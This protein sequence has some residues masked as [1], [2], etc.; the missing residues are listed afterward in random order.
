[1][2]NGHFAIL[3]TALFCVRYLV[4]NLD[5]AG[6]RLDHFLGEKISCFFITKA[7]INI[8][9]NRHNMR[10]KIVNFSQSRVD[11]TAGF[12]RLIQ[13]HKKMPQFARI[14]LLQKCVDLV[15]QC[16][17]GC[18]FMHALVGERPKFGAQSRNHPATQIDI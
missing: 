13:I 1:M 12:P 2:R 6:A 7:R 9:N 11:I 17:N 5:T 15:D 8:C 16:G 14:G 4:F 3:V 10:F 18:F